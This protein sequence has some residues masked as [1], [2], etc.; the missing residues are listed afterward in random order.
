MDLLEVLVV[1]WFL[2][3]LYLQQVPRYR[4]GLLH[5]VLLALQLAPDVGVCGQTRWYKH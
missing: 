1:L 4:W 5:H 3:V 2:V